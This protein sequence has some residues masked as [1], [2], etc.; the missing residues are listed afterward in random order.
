M[1]F[2]SALGK[3]FWQYSTAS[4][5]TGMDSWSQDEPSTKKKK[6]KKKQF[7]NWQGSM[8]AQDLVKSKS[9]LLEPGFEIDQSICLLLVFCEKTLSAPINVFKWNAWNCATSYQLRVC[10]PDRIPNTIGNW[11]TL[12]IS[13][14]LIMCPAPPPSLPSSTSSHR[15]FF[16]IWKPIS[17]VIR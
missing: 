3:E 1:L 12:N 9:L 2:A 5:T 8:L 16:P 6:K 17:L 15:N 11:E 10:I 14:Q 13:S 4:Q 7:S